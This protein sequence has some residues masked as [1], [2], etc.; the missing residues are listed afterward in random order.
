MVV[1]VAHS[2]RFRS[3][4]IVGERAA[5]HLLIHLLDL[6]GKSIPHIS[7]NSALR[8]EFATNRPDGAVDFLRTLFRTDQSSYTIAQ[9]LKKELLFVEHFRGASRPVA[10]ADHTRSQLFGGV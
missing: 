1:R 3:L 2:R 6:G 8:S 10:G 7:S 5:S 9:L 4:Y